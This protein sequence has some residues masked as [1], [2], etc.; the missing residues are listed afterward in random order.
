M[1]KIVAWLVL[2]FVVLLALRMINA[3]KARSRN[4]GAAGAASTAATEMPA[5]AM[6]RCARCGVFLPLS[7]ASTTA[8][9]YACADNECAKR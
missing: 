3:R 5:E 6:V 7:D 9:G 2:I 1:A 8:G 4:G